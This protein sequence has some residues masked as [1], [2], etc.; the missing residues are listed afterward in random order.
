MRDMAKATLTTGNIFI[1]G[2]AGSGRQKVAESLSKT[3]RMD[4]IRFS[5]WL[6]D[7]EPR[8]EGDFTQ[9]AFDAEEGLVRTRLKSNHRAAVSFITRERRLALFRKRCVIDGVYNPADF[10]ALFLPSSDVLFLLGGTPSR[11]SYLPPEYEH[12][13]LRAIWAHCEFL[14]S[15]GLCEENSSILWYGDDLSSD[16]AQTD[17]I[18]FLVDHLRKLRS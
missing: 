5:D 8:P 4:Y 1:V 9:E 7:T 11:T 2:P 12:L 14:L 3:M 17:A 10:S 18:S 16:E 6:Y 13:G 15:V